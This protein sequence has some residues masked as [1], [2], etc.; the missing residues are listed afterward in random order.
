MKKLTF[1]LF[2]LMLSFAAFCQNNANMENEKAAIMALLEEETAA[3]YANDVDRWSATFVH[4]P[5]SILMGSSKA[6]FTFRKGWNEISDYSETLFST[7]G[8]AENNE[9]KTPIT[10]KIYDNNTAYI[11][12]S[13]KVPNNEAIV[14]CFLEKENGAWKIAFRD[15][16][17]KQGYLAADVMYLNA[18]SYAKSMGKTVEEFAKFT[19]NQFKMGWN[20]NNILMATSYNWSLNSTPDHFTILEQ[21]D[22]HI[23]L[24][25]S[26]LFPNLRNNGVLFNVTYD[27]YL[28]FYKTVME[29]IAE[30]VG[31][32][33]SQEKT[34]DGII[35]SMTKN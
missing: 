10:V 2:A 22:N 1:L 7:V 20:E 4:D 32:V 31:A 33:Y 9:V 11:V 8:N 35:V 27:D 16:L 6:N 34:A 30:H 19:A 23:K 12:Y 5:N 18:I 25:I 3:Y 26:N 15:A 29:S 17:W 14:T 21:D 28:T 13:N 24:S